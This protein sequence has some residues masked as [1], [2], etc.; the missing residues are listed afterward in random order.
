[1][2]WTDFQKEKIRFKEMFKKMK[3]D[4][5]FGREIKE[6]LGRSHLVITY[7]GGQMPWDTDL[8]TIAQ[9]LRIFY[10]RMN[11][12]KTSSPLSGS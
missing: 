10:D 4:T 2:Q 3:E 1:M 8:R 12:A 6:F 9:D 7:E 5:C 11:T